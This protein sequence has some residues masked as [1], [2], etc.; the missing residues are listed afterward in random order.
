MPRR[1]AYSTIGQRCYDTHDW[2]A[3]GRINAIGAII[4][5]DFVTV[6]LFEGN[7]NANV[8]YA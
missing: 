2:Q 6:S 8:F 4:E 5:F 1:Y 3:K 7:V